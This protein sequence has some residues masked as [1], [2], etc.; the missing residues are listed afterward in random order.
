MYYFDVLSAQ[1]TVKGMFFRT[2]S[3]S[4]L[5]YPS[6]EE[7]LVNC[8]VVRAGAGAFAKVLAGVVDSDKVDRVFNSRRE[9][10]SKA[11][12]STNNARLQQRPVISA[13]FVTRLVFIG[14][15]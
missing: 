13:S 8:A 2:R 5:F 1:L 3:N 12:V 7:S 4:L 14:T 10:G 9:L 15:N 6:S 11:D